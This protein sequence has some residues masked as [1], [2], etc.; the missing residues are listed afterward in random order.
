MA[1]R[2]DTLTTDKSADEA[3]AA[4]K[5]TLE[6]LDLKVK[7]AGAGTLEAKGGSYFLTYWLGLFL[8][9]STMPVKVTYTVSEKGGSRTI[10]MHTHSGVL[11]ALYKW[12]FHRR[13]NEVATALSQGVAAKLG[14]PA[15]QPAH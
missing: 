4:G 11:L 14:L 8:P 2:T 13:M 3:L 15:P 10:E 9:T 1:N 7:E 5:Q 12:K 6:S